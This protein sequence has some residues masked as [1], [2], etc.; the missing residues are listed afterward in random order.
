MKIYGRSLVLFILVVALFGCNGNDKSDYT[1]VTYTYGGDEGGEEDAASFRE[2]ADGEQSFVCQMCGGS[3]MMTYF[4]GS[5]ITCIGCEGQGIL[6]AD[7]LRQ[8]Y[9]EVM[10]DYGN[11]NSNG[12]SSPN[13][14]GNA[15]ED[16]ER[17]IAW[18]ERNLE[19]LYKQQ[20]YIEGSINS[21]RIRQ[22]I[23]EEEYAIKR[24]RRRLESM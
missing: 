8:K 17:E 20:E 2:G 7:Y 9:D 4:D 6:T 23:I 11:G 13:Y 18:H 5:L 24:L 19:L 15:S 21:N 10:G 12:S 14:D 1:P 16:I 3:G 22:E